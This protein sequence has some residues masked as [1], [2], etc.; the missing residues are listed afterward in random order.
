MSELIESPEERTPAATLVLDEAE[1]ELEPGDS[2]PPP[3]RKRRGV[4]FAVLSAACVL[5]AAG[6]VVA[7]HHGAG[8]PPAA[9]GSAADRD[10]IVSRPH[11]FLSETSGNALNDYPLAIAP[12]DNPDGPRYTPGFSCQRVYFAAGKGLCLTLGHD[13]APGRA[14]TFDTNF[15]MLHTIPATGVP[16]RARVSADGRYGAMT[17]FVVGDAYTADGQFSTRTAIIDMESGAVVANLE[18]FTVYKDGQ[19]FHSPDINFWGVTFAKDSNQ[20]YATLGTA[21]KTYLIQGDIAARTAHTLIEN[22]ECPSLSPDNR[23]IVLDLA[24]MQQKPLAETRNVDD[25]AEWLDNDHV[26]YT[27]VAQHPAVWSVAIDG[28]GQPKLVAS[29]VVS[30]AVVH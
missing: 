29:G 12:L 13:P 19:V 17:F 9:A 20:F 28:S 25:Q 6:Y 5:I 23:H 10:A 21:G 24:T 4:L 22:V 15:Q 8:K 26:L 11:L 27:P 1:Y 16:S 30:P 2:P 3:R 7:A 14:F 18:D